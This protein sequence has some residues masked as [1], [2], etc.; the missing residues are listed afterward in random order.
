[1]NNFIYYLEGSGKSGLY[2]K[3]TPRYPAER[4]VLKT[5]KA[6]NAIRDAYLSNRHLGTYSAD[7]QQNYYGVTEKDVEKL[8][9]L[10]RVC[11]AARHPP[12]APRAL[13]AILSR[14]IFER[15]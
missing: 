3:G 14:E 9:R 7:L 11:A 8:L 1:M 2:K 6:F 15:V 5:Y 13:R 4:K 12:P 10:C